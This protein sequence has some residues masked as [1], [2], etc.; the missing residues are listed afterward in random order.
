LLRGLGES[1]GIRIAE[2][3]G[4]FEKA[5]TA[6]ATSDEADNDLFTRAARVQRT[7]HTER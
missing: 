7:G 5:A 3:V 4:V 2:V 1:G 6:P